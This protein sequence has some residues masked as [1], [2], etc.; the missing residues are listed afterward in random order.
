MFQVYRACE[1]VAVL[2]FNSTLVKEYSIYEFI[3]FSTN[4]CKSSDVEKSRFDEL[5]NKFEIREWAP[6]CKIKNKTTVV[7]NFFVAYYLQLPQ[8]Y[9]SA[10]EEEVGKLVGGWNFPMGKTAMFTRCTILYSVGTNSGVQPTKFRP[11]ST[12][13][14]RGKLKLWGLQL[15]QLLYPTSSYWYSYLLPLCLNNFRANLRAYR[16]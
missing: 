6:T 2:N 10:Q 14:L 5:L 3:I 13:T 12:L 15:L 8:L 1:L 4:Y 16:K 9:P 11:A 7:L